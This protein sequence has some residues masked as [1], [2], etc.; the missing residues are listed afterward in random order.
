MKL[1]D[2]YSKI[3]VIHWKPLIERKEYLISKFKEFGIIDKVEWV[4]QY[5]T[6]ETVKNIPNPFNLKKRLIAANMSHIYCYRQQIKNKYKNILIIED[7]IDFESIHIVNFFNQCAK[8][9]V[10]LDGDIAFL[11]SCCHLKVP[12]ITPPKLLYYDP[13]FG[14]RCTGCYIVNIRSVKKIL[15]CSELN[16]H[17]VD[18][19]LGALIPI[20]NIRCLWS[21]LALKQGSESGKYK[22][23]VVELRDENGNYNE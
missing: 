2:F 22:S 11:G 10:E 4:D 3:Y 8:E 12:K 19:I 18:R 20:I 21:G 9:F 13:S 5:D 23:S 16:C 17:A 6:E 1:D 14:S 15:L 7:D